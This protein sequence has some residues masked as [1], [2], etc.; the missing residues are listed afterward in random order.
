MNFNDTVKRN[1]QGYRKRAGLTQEEVAEKLSVTRRTIVDYEN[2]PGKITMG[3]YVK[4][5]DMYGVDLYSF[6]IPLN[7]TISENS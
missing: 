2:N 6:F 5:A 3:T 1:L 7:F 4:L